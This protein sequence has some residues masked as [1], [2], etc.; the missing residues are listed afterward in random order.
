MAE[1]N[2]V[3]AGQSVWLVIVKATGV[4]IEGG[5]HTTEE[6]AR[7]TVQQL[8]DDYPNERGKYEVRAV[9]IEW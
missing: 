5:A 8:E 1:V 6:R 2:K 3:G 9:E 7:G 4:P